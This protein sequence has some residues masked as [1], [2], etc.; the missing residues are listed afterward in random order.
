MIESELAEV[1]P[2]P[3]GDLVDNAIRDGRQLRR[4]RLVHRSVAC[5]AAVGALVLGLGMATATLRPDGVP[6]KAGGEV[7]VAAGE[8]SASASRTTGVPVGTPTMGLYQAKQNYPGAESKRSPAAPAAVLIALGAVLPP[9]QTV[10]YA[11]GRFDTYT[12]VQIFLDRGEGFGMVRVAVARYAMTPAR[13][14][15]GS[16]GVLVRCTE[17]EGAV[18]ETFEI[19]SNCV[20]RRGVNVYRADGIA[21]QVNVGSCLVDGKWES[22]ST[23]SVDEQVLGVNEAVKIGLAP[24]WNERTMS[25]AAAKASQRY[26]DLP[27]LTAFDGVGG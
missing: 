15:G 1:V 18:V 21:I 11:G 19:E 26:P 25:D 14:C 13:D 27:I 9:G 7:G 12:G 17:E 5:V 4:I 6:D 8:L 23:D 16:P 3:I 10:G 20:Q 22:P 2:P 24:V